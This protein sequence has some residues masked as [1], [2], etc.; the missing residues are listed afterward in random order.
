MVRSYFA[1]GPALA[2]IHAQPLPHDHHQQSVTD[3]IL[4]HRADSQVEFLLE[5][6]AQPPV[7]LWF[8]GQLLDHTDATNNKTWK[9]RY[10]VNKDYFGGANSPVFLY[11]NG[12]GAADASTPSSPN[13]FMN[14]LAQKYK[15]IIVSL[16]HRFYGS[17]QPTGDLTLESLK[18]LT[19]GQA[20]ADI[21]SFQD[22]FIGQNHLTKSNPWI[23]IGGS[24]PGMLSGLVK[25]KYPTRF[26]GSIASSA[27]LNTKIDFFEYADIVAKDL[28]TYGGD[29]CVKTIGD[30][31]TALNALVASNNPSDWASLNRL[32][33][34]CL[35]PTGGNPFQDD[36]DRAA[37]QVNVLS[38]FRNVAQTNGFFPYTMA[39][40]CQDFA[41]NA[42]ATPLEK[43]SA[44]SQQQWGWDAYP[45]ISFTYNWQFVTSYQDTTPNPSLSTRQWTYQQCNEFGYGQAT[46]T[47]KSIFNALKYLTV[48]TA[49]S[50]TCKRLFGITNTSDRIAATTKTYGG[51]KVNVSNVIWVTGDVDPWSGLALTNTTKPVNSNS[52]V[53]Y[54]PGASHCADLFSRAFN[55]V[56]GWTH[57]RI[58][59]NVAKFLATMTTVAPTPAPTR[60]PTPSPTRAP[61]P[62]PFNT[63]SPSATKTPVTKAPVT[64][65]P[66]PDQCEGNTKTCFWPSNHASLPYNEA[67]CKSFGSLFLWCP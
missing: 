24:Y 3:I 29:A 39:G 67:D 56:P 47:G 59:N 7:D 46:A 1:V 54:V 63:L 28:Q 21:A 19:M 22:Y 55:I 15:A 57:D 26:A 44:F 32:F 35:P 18:Y 41:K 23:A 27:P 20:L 40:V 14:E 65:A 5:A 45:C 58:D 34:V 49:Y 52:D 43:L 13:F 9:Q 51:L 31:L 2:I 37:F 33:K 12:E 16:E 25:A 64:K 30:G 48:D 17:S 62:T 66:V 42:S 53:V 36:Y 61:A 38:N 6:F 11:I 50:E 10:H 4:N 8:E 60:A